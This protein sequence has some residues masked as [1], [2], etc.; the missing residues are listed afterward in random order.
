MEQ[1]LLSLVGYP[2][3]VCFL[4]LLLLGGKAAPILSDRLRDRYTE[5]CGLHDERGHG[6]V[7]ARRILPNL[8]REQ[9]R[10]FLVILRWLSDGFLVVY[11]GQARSCDILQENACIQDVK[12]RKKLRVR[13]QLLLWGLILDSRAFLGF[14]LVF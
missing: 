4:P 14:T 3:F 8:G 5:R 9:N 12:I 11:M 10:G 6:G 1:S 13:R 7:F 2:A